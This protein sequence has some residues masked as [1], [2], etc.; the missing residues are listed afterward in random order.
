M[1][2]GRIK[3]SV[4]IGDLALETD[5]EA[6]ATCFFRGVNAY[7]QGASLARPFYGWESWRSGGY[8]AGYLYA[9]SLLQ[10][11]SQQMVLIADA[12]DSK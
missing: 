5:D 8:S 1:P 6:F 11:P 9:R 2:E 4:K 10:Q 3:L 12:A 7:A